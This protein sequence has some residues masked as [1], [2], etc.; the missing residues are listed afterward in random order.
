MIC[1]GITIFK[2]VQPA[3][4]DDESIVEPVVIVLSSATTRVV[5]LYGMYGI[6]LEVCR[7]SIRNAKIRQRPKTT[8]M[9]RNVNIMQVNKKM[10]IVGR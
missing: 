10:T 2:K 7:A 3:V 8:S 6:L 4:N 5:S 9:H 1:N